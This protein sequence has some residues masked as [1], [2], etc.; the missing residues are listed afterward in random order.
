MI[1]FHS[2]QIG[3]YVDLGLEMT[4]EKT[5]A[6]AESIIRNEMLENDKTIRAARKTAYVLLLH[7][8]FND[9]WLR[10]EFLPELDEQFHNKLSEMPSE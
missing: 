10:N 8:G 1:Q 4:P 6:F 5:K 3:G 2:K 7:L 9:N